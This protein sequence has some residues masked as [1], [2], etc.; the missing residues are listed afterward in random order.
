M[1][2]VNRNCSAIVDVC[3]GRK[4]TNQVNETHPHF[5]HHWTFELS[6]KDRA[7]S[8]CNQV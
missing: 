1:G 3:L 4:T 7:R 8:D 5:C 6:M 2:R